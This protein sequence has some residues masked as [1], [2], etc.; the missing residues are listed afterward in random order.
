[1]PSSADNHKAHDYAERIRERLPRRQ[2]E[3]RERA[4]LSRYA[5]AERPTVFVKIFPVNPP[6]SDIQ[7]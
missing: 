2:Q 3:L 5:L 4:G 1:M 6:W 7:G